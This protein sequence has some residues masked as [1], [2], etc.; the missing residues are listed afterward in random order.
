VRDYY[1]KKGKIR[2][3]DGNCAEAET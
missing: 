1:T 2:Y 3:I